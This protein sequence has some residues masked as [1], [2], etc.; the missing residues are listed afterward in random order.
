MINS[1]AQYMTSH[2]RQNSSKAQRCK[3]QARAQLLH[4]L[5]ALVSQFPGKRCKAN[6][7]AWERLNVLPARAGRGV[8]PRV[9]AI[10]SSHPQTAFPFPSSPSHK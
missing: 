2:N 8:D 10:A 3:P 7:M 5:S 4:V 1:S 6:F 9:S